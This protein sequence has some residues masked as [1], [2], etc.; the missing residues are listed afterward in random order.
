MNVTLA[1]KVTLWWV[2]TFLVTIYISNLKGVKLCW[3]GVNYKVTKVGLLSFSERE[4]YA[5]TSKNLNDMDGQLV[6]LEW[7]LVINGKKQWIRETWEQY[8]HRLVTTLASVT[9]DS[10]EILHFSAD[11]LQECTLGVDCNDIS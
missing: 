10:E 11:K 8:S 1:M 5:S 3:S 7:K 2:G 9:G 6:S 4:F